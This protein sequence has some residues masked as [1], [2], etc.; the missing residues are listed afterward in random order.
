MSV[1]PPPVPVRS[2]E[3]L[4]LVFAEFQDSIPSVVRA[5]EQSFTEVRVHHP[6]DIVED[7]LFEKVLSAIADC[8]HCLFTHRAAHSRTR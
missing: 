5:A 8:S 1:C 2:S 3:V 4:W 7:F 6:E